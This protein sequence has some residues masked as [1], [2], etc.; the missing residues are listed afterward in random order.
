MKTL[1]ACDDDLIAG[2][3]RQAMLRQGLDLP[4]SNVVTLARASNRLDEA[5]PDLVAVS[6]SPSTE[7]GLALI[8]AL[9]VK[10]CGP[11]IAVGPASSKLVLRA[12]RGGADDYIDDEEIESELG[13]VVSR[14]KATRSTSTPT[15]QGRTIAVLAPSGGSGS[16][17]IAANIATVLAKEHKSVALVDLKFHS[18]DLA[19]LLDLKPAFTLADICQNVQRLDQVMLEHSLAKH[20]S[21][22]HLL[23]PPRLLADVAHVTVE[24]VRRSL[25]LARGMF[26]Y[27]VIDLDH[28]FHIEQIEAL[29]TAD[30]VLLV[31]RLDFASLRNAKRTLEHLEYMG[32]NPTQIRLVVNRYGQPKEVPAAKA[33]EALGVK[34]AHYIPDDPKSVNRAN[35]NGV[36]V[37]LET[38]SAKVSRSV[39][40]LAISVNG[41]HTKHKMIEGPAHLGG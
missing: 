19:A 39:T 34:I 29:R 22:V 11:I 32:V 24:G 35:N 7:G 20:E 33:E 28:T 27:V 16:S 36:P 8:S 30:I 1:L 4:A 13:P 41:Q 21:G 9:K 10:G 37:V 3:I 25:E 23:A 38:P 40:K 31:I 18:G 17:T 26:P 2:T 15:H 5:Q 14:L 6:L 12:L